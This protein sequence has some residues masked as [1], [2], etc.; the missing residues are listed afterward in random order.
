[1][2]DTRL[3]TTYMAGSVTQYQR[4]IQ[5]ADAKAN[6]VLVLIGVI[7]SMFFNFIISKETP[8]TPQ[9]YFVLLPFVIS[10]YFAFLTLF[11]RMAKKSGK[12]SLIYFKDCKDI[13]V[14]K[15]TQK[16]LQAPE[17]EIYEDYVTNIKALAKV[18]NN[19]FNYLRLAYIF[20]AIAI[21]CKVA[22]E[23]TLWL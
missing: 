16:L 20:F 9:I 10:G 2:K 12:D 5:L 3:V 23:L 17:K 6:I 19:K 15:M 21:L 18:I 13:D 7:V 4:L 22:F 8:F 14:K 11:P 1:M